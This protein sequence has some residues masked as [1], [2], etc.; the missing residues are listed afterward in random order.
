M[1]INLISDTVTKPSQEMLRYMF[2]AEVGDDVYKQD[3]SV[4]AL[5][6]KVAE[7][8]GMEAA[9]FFPS[10]TMANQTAIKL[11]TQ[12]G[13]QL[14]ADKWAHVFNYEAGGVAFNSG[15]SCS[16]LDGNRG[17]ITA[18]QVAGAVNDPEFYH[19]PLTSLVCVENTTNKG[20]G[21]CY[22]I[23]ELQKIKQVCDAKNL[24]FHLDGARLWNAL[25]A[26]K[27]HPTQYG[28][29]FD[30]ISVC[31]SKGLGAPIGSLLLSNKATIHKALRVRKLLGGGMRQAGYLA[32]AGIYALDNNIG[33]LEEDHRRAKELGAALQKLS[34]IEKVEPIETNI[35]IFSVKKGLD[36]NLLIAKLK[37]RNIHISSM[38][39]GKLR[40]VTHLDYREV[41]HSYVLETLE[42]IGTK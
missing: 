8:F 4:N 30:T 16:L 24:K 25:V 14:I 11:L 34:W 1:E 21:A 20:G 5:E 22:N 18:E 31:L 10:G 32:A 3:P 2:Q 19:S 39:H 35:L 38:G 36:E 17:M 26:T 7:L 12:P 27:T 37:E 33:R 41:M 23:E 15:V 28:A 29:L 42:R 9:L 13:E 6:T 40:I